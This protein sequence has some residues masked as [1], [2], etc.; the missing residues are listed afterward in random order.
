MF[1]CLSNSSLLC[2]F[3][4]VDEELRTKKTNADTRKQFQEET[5][6]PKTPISEI[7]NKSDAYN[8]FKLSSSNKSEA[9]NLNYNW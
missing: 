7:A 3:L 2:L 5:S 4:G 1:D 6:S 9:Y 8:I